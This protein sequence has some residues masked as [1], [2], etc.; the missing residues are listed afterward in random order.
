[1]P[2][3]SVVAAP[4]VDAAQKRPHTIRR[5]L[6]SRGMMEAVT[7]SFLDAKTAQQFDGGAASLTLVNPI[8]ADLD[9]MRPSI[10]PNLLA[11]LMRNTAR[12]E[13]DAAIFE[14]GP[15]FPGDGAD[16][17]RTSA[18]GLRHGMTAPR[19]WSGAA[20][21]VDW[22][23]A[24]GDAIAVLAALGVNTASLQTF[25]E[26]PH[27]YHPGQSGALFQGRNVL[28]H[29]GAIH[30]AVLEAFDLKG[31]AAGFEIV[32]ENVNLP[33]AKGPARPLAQL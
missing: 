24:R 1:L 26:A 22:A 25:A 19:E 16:E 20:R 30:P 31:P 18:T 12:G 4:A 29:F 17:Q 8:S 7:F 6:A 5:L 21:P 28:A 9:T 27:W 11:A 13:S 10:M 23:D 3:L 15:I 2:R 14:V 32:L 33:K